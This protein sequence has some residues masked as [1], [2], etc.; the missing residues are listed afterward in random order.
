MAKQSGLSSKTDVLFQRDKNKIDR[1]CRIVHNFA[2]RIQQLTRNVT[3]LWQMYIEPKRSTTETATKYFLRFAK[4][5]RSSNIR[6]G[7]APLYN[8]NVHAHKD[9]RMMKERDP[10][11]ETRMESDGILLALADPRND[12]HTGCRSSDQNILPDLHNG[13]LFSLGV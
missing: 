1:F 11:V 6:H 4:F 8:R 13:C 10:E 9:L 5:Q 7:S 12:Q 3:T 2:A